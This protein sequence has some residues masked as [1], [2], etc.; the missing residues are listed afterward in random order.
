MNSRYK[1]SIVDDNKAFRDGLRFFI[2]NQT[3]WEIISEESTGVDFLKSEL[4]RL[5]QIIFIDINMPL[6]NG[7]ETVYRFF[8]KYYR[9]DIVVI[10][11][12]MY[13][14]DYQV[15]TLIEAGF[16]GCI[17]KKDVYRCLKP[18]VDKI[19]GGGV[20]YDGFIRNSKIQ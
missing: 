6:L 12:T 5:P 4:T 20:Y 13:A 17:L 2:E 8:E 1:V 11:I 3:D 15:Q 18:A 14:N 7:I 19:I 10:G 16:K 9:Y